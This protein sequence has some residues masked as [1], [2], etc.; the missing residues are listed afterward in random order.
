MC[1]T[2]C[3]SQDSVSDGTFL[4][5]GLPAGSYKVDAVGE[6]VDGGDYG[7]IR[8]HI[9]VADAEVVAL[10]EGLYMP[11]MVGP[12]TVTAGEHTF[13]TVTW[14]VS[15]ADVT[16]PFGYEEDRYSVGV[17]AGADIPSYYG[18]A[19]A[20]AV[21]FYPLATEVSAPFGVV[22]TGTGVA[23]GTYDV[24]AVSALGETEGPVGTAVA[25]GGTLTAA[26]VQPAVLSWL[27][28]VPQG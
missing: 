27:L 25:A 9:E 12:Q 2:I 16:V 23:D 3:Y 10:P 5:T 8:I 6:S 4:F 7:R 17:V 15:A 14:T 11:K 13:G 1:E 18:V 20:Y 22:A 26:S 21:A 24:Y 28:F 19:A